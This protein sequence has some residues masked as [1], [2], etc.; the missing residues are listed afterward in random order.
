M[1]LAA[2]ATWAERAFADLLDGGWTELA[3]APDNPKIVECWQYVDETPAIQDDDTS[4]CSAYAN[5]V[6]HLAGYRGTRNAAARSWAK[7]GEEVPLRVGAIAVFWRG[8]PTSWSGHVGIV[9]G[10]ISTHVF[11]LGGNQTD[12]LTVTAIPRERLLTCRWATGAQR[13]PA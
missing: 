4:W 11:V 10:W 6:V 3:G 2:R 7:W 5:R 12:S 1:T 13:L 8:S 9:V